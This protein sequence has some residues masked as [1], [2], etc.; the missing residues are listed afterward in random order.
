MFGWGSTI[1]K[2][3]CCLQVRVAV[4]ELKLSYQNGCVY[5]Y[6]VSNRVS[7]I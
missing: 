1:C 7:P 2:E 4:T 3:L 5:I 6:I